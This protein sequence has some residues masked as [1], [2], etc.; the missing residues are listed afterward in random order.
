MSTT[1]RAARLRRCEVQYAL[2][3]GGVDE[4][5]EAYHAL[6][7]AL[8][9]AWPERLLDEIPAEDE[10]PDMRAARLAWLAALRQCVAAHAQLDAAR[11]AEAWPTAAHGRERQLGAISGRAGLR[12]LELSAPM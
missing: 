7:Q 2:A 11:R 8:G 4:A 3:L 6:S 1:S 10:R 12:G 5:A 9:I